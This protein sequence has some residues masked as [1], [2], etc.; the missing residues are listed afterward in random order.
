[1]SETTL[2]TGPMWRGRNWSADT[3]GGIHDDVTATDLGFRGGTVAG[4]IHMDQ[5]VPVL[6][7]IFGDAWLER[8]A[9][10]M[11]F[12]NATIDGEAVRVSAEPT[13]GR[14]QVRV[15]MHRE[16]GMEVMSGTASLSDHSA[17]ELR[18]KDLRPADPSTLR[19]LKNLR[20]G[21]TISTVHSALER[22]KQLGRIR[23]QWM[24]DPIPE[25]AAR[26]PR[27]DGILASPSSVVDLLW[28]VPT[29]IWRKEIGDAVGL[30]GAIEVAQ[31]NGP[32]LLDTEYQVDAKIIALTDSP[33]TEGFWFDSTAHDAAGK[34]IASQRML[35]R[36]MK[37]SSPLYQ[38]A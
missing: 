7:R 20:V 23:R 9:L 32:L 35:L 2:I 30:F 16:D 15:W 25:F 6:R 36:F 5:F 24:S 13:E 26:A 4:N 8:G 27:W 34:F 3:A 14:N 10:S 1:M 11:Y 22:D 33:K 19:I 38:N 17:S 31:Q 18:S 37:A 28:G 12:K 21:K 29:A